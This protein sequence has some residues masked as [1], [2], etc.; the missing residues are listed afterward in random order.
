[1]AQLPKG[2]TFSIA[3]GFDNAVPVTAISNASEAIVTA[4]G[5]GLQDGDIIELLTGWTKLNRR[6][7]KV[8][9]LSTTTFALVGV[10]TSS[11]ASFPPGSSVGSFRK[12]TAWTQV[13]KVMNPQT[14][15]GEPKP[16]TYEFIEDEN[17]Y[18]INNGFSATGYT[19]EIDDDIETPGY[20]AVLKASDE[21]TETVL[22]ILMKGNKNPTYMPTYVAMN[23]IPVLQEGQI[24][25]LRVSFNGRARPTRYSGVVA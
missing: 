20:A 9:Q 6:I 8:D 19:I 4:T 25:R 23:P 22:R 7:F 21:Q 2:A 10:D 12:I 3:T 15:G 13:P 1:M 18:Q 14:S 5:H 17:E 16:V 24:N 11:T